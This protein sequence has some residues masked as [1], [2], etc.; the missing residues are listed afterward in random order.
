MSREELEKQIE[1]IGKEIEGLEILANLG[2]MEGFEAVIEKLKEDMHSNI[3]AENWKA[4]KQNKAEIEKMRSFTNYVE[5]QTE[6]IEDK[7]EE[8]QKLKEQLDNY[9]TN[10]F[11]E[12]SEPNEKEFTDFEINDEELF[13]G[14]LFETQEEQAKLWF[15]GQSSAD[16]RKF[17]ILQEGTDEELSLNYKKNREFLAGLVYLGNVYDNP[18]LLMN[19]E[20]TKQDLL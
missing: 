12:Q 3:K 19:R 13:T 10:M 14:D 2:N 7:E 6:L 1:K 9:Q 4:L 20:E 17:V 5:K 8:L 11:E 15:V 18:E 16:P